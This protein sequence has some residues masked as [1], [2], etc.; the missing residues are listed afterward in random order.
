MHRST[1]IPIALLALVLT[2]GAV[3][4]QTGAL[5]GLA[6][7]IVV[8]ID[9]VV[10]ADVTLAIVQGDGAVVTTTVPITVGVSLQ[11][12]IDGATVVAVAPAAAEP[13]TVAVAAVEVAAAGDQVDA[14]GRAYSTE[15]AENITLDQIESSL[16]ALDKLEIIGDITNTG[17][18]PLKYVQLIATLY[19]E[20][21]SI[22]G[23]ET[24][25]SSL[26]TISPGQTS[27]FRLMAMSVVDGAS[28]AS[29][30]IQIEGD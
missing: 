20:D 4:A 21:G 24:A 10:P 23:V 5:A 6:Q 25:Y 3:A 9:Q 8:T 27:P 16:N 28:V 1:F 2:T 22:L 11:I 29:Y 30:R 12:K 14:A 18:E 15:L 17:D 26:D 7:P 19:A 13:A